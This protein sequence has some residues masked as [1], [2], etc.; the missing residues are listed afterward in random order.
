MFISGF[1]G[2]PRKG[3]NTNYLLRSFMAEAEKQG[4]STEIVH[5]HGKK[6]NPCTGCA[7][8]EKKGLCQFDDDMQ[9]E[10]FP[11][12]RKSDI[13]VIASPVYF[14]NAPSELKALI[15]R[16]QTLWAR[17]YK[18]GLTDTGEKSRQGY[19]LAIG[20]TRFKDLFDG[21]HLTLKYFFRSIPAS[22][23]GELTYNN[24]ENPGD[25]KNH[26]SIDQDIEK[27]V[28]ELMAPFKKRKT[29]L[30]TC[31]QNTGRSQ[32]AGAFAR[33]FA[34]D[35]FNVI[36]AGSMPAKDFPPVIIDVM[37]EKGLDVGFIK[38][39][40]IDSVVAK[41]LPDYAV[42]IEGGDETCIHIA[43][44]KT[45]LWRIQDQDVSQVEGIRK[46]RDEIEERVKKFILTID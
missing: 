21:I 5:V 1:M 34:G 8:C 23:A 35:K 11:L 17:K 24:M 26:P 13:I 2:S 28:T 12:L 22:F 32:M 37:A 40:S 45:T 9:S 16:T 36:T 42:T 19:M 10:I 15:D 20:G 44:S 4:A 29:L 33:H 14:S 38:P 25:M 6:I 30:F 7:L 39:Q 43:G 3:G 41:S 27:A 46:L 31:S 18:L